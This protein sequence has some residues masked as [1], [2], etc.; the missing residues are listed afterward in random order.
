MQCKNPLCQKGC[1]VHTPIR[2]VIKLF[3]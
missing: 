3:K 1:P 2:E